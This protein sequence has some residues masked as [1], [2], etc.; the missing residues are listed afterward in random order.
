M[1]TAGRTRDAGFRAYGYM[2]SVATP[3][4]ERQLSATPIGRIEMAYSPHMPLDW[5]NEPSQG[6]GPKQ[7]L[8]NPRT[9]AL[10]N[11]QF[12]GAPGLAS[13]TWA[14]PKEIRLCPCPCFCRCPC[15]SCCHSP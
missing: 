5:C 9:T 6:N 2:R 1:A 8:G 7:N 14:F 11:P 15:F 12:A 4:S 3:V 10:G 13:E